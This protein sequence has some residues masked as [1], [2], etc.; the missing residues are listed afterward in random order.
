MAF[1]LH[2]LRLRFGVGLNP[3][4]KGYF[5]IDD[6]KQAQTKFFCNPPLILNIANVP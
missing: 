1:I 6:Y 2:K 5:M 3:N 4:S